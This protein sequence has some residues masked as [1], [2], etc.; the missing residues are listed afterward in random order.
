VSVIRIVGLANGQP[1]DAAGLYV[2]DYTPDGHDGRGDLVLTD[3]QRQAKVYPD[4]AA[5]WAD[6][7]RTSTTHPA[8]ETDGKPNRPM[9]AFTVE[10]R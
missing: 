10:I 2:Q 4:A 3:D 1:T 9:T 6:W 8:R 5:A 7:R